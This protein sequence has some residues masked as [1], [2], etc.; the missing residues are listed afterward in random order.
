MLTIRPERPDEQADVA[1]VVQL[2]FGGPAEARLVAALRSSSAG[3]PELSLV[4]LEG[5]R[6]VGHVAFSHVTLRDGALRR[7]ALALAP[8]SVLPERQRQG[9]GSALLGRGLER[10]AALGHALVI[11]VGHPA[12][13]PRFG[14]VPGEPLGLR[15]SFP[16]SPGALM[17][18]ELRRGALSD[19]RGLVEYA[20]AFDVLEPSPSPHEWLDEQT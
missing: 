12:Y 4:A 2:A 13:Y 3:I 8:L 19:A 9:V 7:P 20:P 10:A 6:V 5:E 1:R 16:T 15:T 18:C 14:F 11:V 17:A